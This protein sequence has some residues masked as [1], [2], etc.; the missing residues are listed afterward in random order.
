MNASDSTC[1]G[2]DLTQSTPLLAVAGG[3]SKAEQGI[4]EKNC[5][6][7]LLPILPGES[8][9]TG[10]TAHR[11][12]RGLGESWPPECQAP[13]D[14]NYR[15][16]VGRVPLVCAWN[17]LASQS[18]NK[19]SGF[20]RDTEIA[21]NP[22]GRKKF[23]S[24][25]E[26]IIGSSVKAW[27]RLFCSDM[28]TVV[29]PDSLGEAAQ[30]ALVD[31][32]GSF[33]IPR[34]IAVSM[35][36][37]R[38]HAGD[39][40]SIDVKAARGETI[41]HLLIVT[42]P[43]DQ[44]EVVP[45]EI[46]AVQDRGKIWLVPVRNRV[47]GGGEFPRYG[48]NFFLS[49]A[50]NRATDRQSAWKQAFGAGFSTT[51]TNQAEANSVRTCV[52]NGFDKTARGYFSEFKDLSSMFTAG[53]Q[54][55]PEAF[56]ELLSEI[57]NR[58]NLSL[59]DAAQKTCLGVIIDG[60]CSLIPVG[61]NHT[62]GEFVSRAFPEIEATVSGGEEASIGAALTAYALKHDLPS[63]RETILPIDIHYH[64]R[65]KRG[66]YQ[67]AYKP[68]VEGK[69]V[70]AGEEFK[71]NE[72]L[73]GL[74]IN[75]SEKK[76]TLTLRRTEEK[77]A[78]LFRKVTAE[79]TKET[80]RDEEVQIVA[81]LK[82]GQGFAKVFIDSVN[83]GVFNTRLDW[84]TMEDCEEPPPPPLAYL[85][86]VSYIVQDSYLWENAETYVE[87]AIKALRDDDSFISDAM[88]RL[89]VAAKF[90]YWPLADSLDE[91]RGVVPKGD[92]FRHYG[93]CPSDSNL[94]HTKNKEKLETLARESGR[95]FIS[96]AISTSQRKKIQQAISW[97]YLACP[98]TIIHHVRTNLTNQLAQVQ[99][100]DLHTIGL[101]WCESKDIE[102]FFKALEQRLSQGITGV[103]NWLRACRNI[104]R[105]RDGAL[106]PNIIQ[107]RRL[108]R[109][110]ESLLRI[111]DGQIQQRNFSRI[112]DNCIL[113]VLYLLKRRR[114]RKEFLNDEEDELS[115]LEENFEKLLQQHSNSLSDRQYTIIKVTLK[116]LKKEASLSDLDESVLT[117]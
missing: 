84:R 18:I 106:H 96:R 73:R 49:M 117:G 115:R 58:Q 66:D 38:R 110:V 43:F 116:F 107:D 4:S 69:T 63:Y 80:T 10:L 75:Q 95:V 81:H 94:A 25:A 35:A 99:A 98:H 60:S 54:L 23:S 31:N 72:A 113:T 85:P 67:N 77:E 27:E 29:I 16:G 93:V 100:E 50:S 12:R 2:I 86:N 11:H 74:H 21:W 76:L 92:I 15:H 88:D 7:A 71:S 39:F 14:G 82:P 37:C 83:Q 78:Y 9:I 3:P 40:S 32:C 44:W 26:R 17:K 101:C 61:E 34:P 62:L 19:F 8:I 89:R 48:V 33:L 87:E 20:L 36:W 5:P 91:Y 51:S 42:T 52:K 79:I 47:A 103:N 114:Y 55:V 104:V 45:I 6:A 111:L 68:L 56:K 90:N 105:F 22:S 108:K 112:F 30:Q 70:R 109:I 65:D 46:R 28:T 59:P 13:I 57:Y 41:G 102:L 53:T 97:M 1:I 64:G 24:T